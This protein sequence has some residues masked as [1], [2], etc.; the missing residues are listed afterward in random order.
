MN[1]SD[2]APPAEPGIERIL[3]TVED[4]VRREPLKAS[5]MAFGAGL[6]LKVLPARAIA[7]PV[8]TLAVKLLPP[9]LVGLGMLK[10]LEICCQHEPQTAGKEAPPGHP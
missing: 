3:S 7:R 6:L 1:A 8:A 4:Y 9:A 2:S 5:A 10:A